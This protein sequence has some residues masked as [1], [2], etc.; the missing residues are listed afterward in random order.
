MEY[1]YRVHTV[2]HIISLIY[3]ILFIVIGIC[4]LTIN[5][6]GSAVVFLLLGLIFSIVTLL[7]GSTIHISDTG[8]RQ[9]YFGIALRTLKWHEIAEVGVIGTKVFNK[10]HPERAGTLYIYFSKV[11]LT[12][13]DRFSMILKWPPFKKIYLQYTDNRFHTI[14]NFWSSIIETYNI[15]NLPL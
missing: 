15:G 5:R 6:Y 14:Q 11:K 4:L 1:K 3:F 8:I 13:E 2:K 12:N 7:T 9:T 10:K